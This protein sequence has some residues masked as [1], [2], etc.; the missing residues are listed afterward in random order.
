[1]PYFKCSEQLASEH[2]RLHTVDEWPDGPRKKAALDAI[3]SALESLSR[4]PASSDLTFACMFCNPN[5]Q[6]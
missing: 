2:H 3:L 4:H 5:G 6:H 1:M